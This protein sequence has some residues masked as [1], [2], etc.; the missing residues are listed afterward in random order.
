MRRLLSRIFGSPTS[1]IQRPRPAQKARRRLGIEALD[2]RCVPATLQLAN[3]LLTYNAGAGIVNRLTLSAIGN[4]SYVLTDASETI[5]APGF[6]G[7]GTNSVTIPNILV[8][9]MAF[10]LGD[11]NDAIV[12]EQTFDP[13][14]VKGGSGNDTVDIGKVVGGTIGSIL[15]PITFDGEAD[16]DALRVNDQGAGGASNYEITATRVTPIGNPGYDYTAVE[17]VTVTTGEENE[18]FTIRSTAF[19]TTTVVNAGGGFDT[20]NVGSVTNTLDDL[21]GHLNLIGGTNFSHPFFFPDRVFLFDQGSTASNSYAVRPNSVAR[22]GGVVVEYSGVED[23]TLNAGSATDSA[24]VIGTAPLVYVTMNMG[25]GNDVVDVATRTGSSMDLIGYVVQVNGQAG[26]DTVNLNDNTDGNANSYAIDSALVS[27]NGTQVVG[28]GTIESLNLNGGA[29]GDTI[30]VRGTVFSTPVTIKSGGG[31]DTVNVGSASNSLDP[32]IGR[33]TI[34]GQAG[35]D[36]LTINDQGTANY[37]EYFVTATEISR[38]AGGRVAYAGAES[39]TLNGASGTPFNDYNSNFFNILST[40]APT[41]INGA[42]FIYNDFLV[43]T[44]VGTLDPIQGELTVNG[45]GLGYLLLSDFNDADANSYIVT[46]ST[47]A[48]SGAAL[49]TYTTTGSV[50]LYA[51]AGNNVADIQSTSAATPVELD[52]GGGFDLATLGNGFLALDAVATPVNLFADAVILNDANDAFGGN[53]Y[54]VS[55]SGVI[56]NNRTI[57]PRLT[58]NLT[59]IAGS[60]A[61]TIRV[62]NTGAGSQVTL[63]GGPGADRFVWDGASAVSSVNVD[64]QG[65]VD[66]LDYTAFFHPGSVYVNLALGTATFFSGGVGNIENV[67]GS[68]G[69]DIIVGNDFANTLSGFAGRDI[70]IG[71]NGSDVLSGGTEDD[72]L[73]GSRTVYDLNTSALADIMAE[74]EREDIVGTAQFQYLT[75]IRHLMGTLPGGENGTTFLTASKVIDDAAADTLDGGAGLDWYFQ[76]GSDTIIGLGATERVN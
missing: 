25:G 42:S 34:D 13:I 52:L 31:N 73:I 28:Y 4:Q 72:I 38:A 71:R 18:T 24:V 70:L 19:G 67:F 11:G 10:N 68:P 16:S 51:G 60:S 6:A 74:W 65:D 59:L 27:R 35:A 66:T 57:V 3:G 54:R 62:G 39:V 64:G 47:V 40:S 30:S 53:D 2:D 37:N 20:F 21:R 58:P 63:R 9:S 46:E 76:L 14:V 23:V 32:I 56:R 50:A 26:I 36:Q 55:S 41:T 12:I 61:D 15:A 69:N 45:S 17:R 7:S 1:P 22:S 48:R 8:S 49:I 75:R 44:N 43:G 29:F 5:S 33:V